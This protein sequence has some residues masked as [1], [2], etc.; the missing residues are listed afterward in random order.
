MRHTA[1]LERL[2]ETL[3]ASEGEKH[4]GGSVQHDMP[5]PSP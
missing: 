4:L 3:G 1:L 2:R 5:T